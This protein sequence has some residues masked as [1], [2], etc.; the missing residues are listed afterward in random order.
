MFC[1]NLTVNVVEMPLMCCRGCVIHCLVKISLPK[2]GGCVLVP[3]RPSFRFYIT[4]C[5]PLLVY[6]TNVLAELS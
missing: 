2:R 6:D 3:F 1:H 4:I 5:A